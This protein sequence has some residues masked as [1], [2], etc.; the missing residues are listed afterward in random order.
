[1]RRMRCQIE[2]LESRNLLT[3]FSASL[4]FDVTEGQGS[5]RFQDFQPAETGLLFSVHPDQLWF[6]DGSTDGTVQLSSDVDSL[7]IGE[8]VRA[9]DTTY[10]SVGLTSIWRT[11]GTISGSYELQFPDEQ[12]R[13][14]E[15]VHAREGFAILLTHRSDQ[16]EVWRFDEGQANAIRL[17]H[18]PYNQTFFQLP[19]VI[20]AEDNERLYIGR[21]Q[22]SS[23]L[24]ST[25]G[26]VEG[27]EWVSESLEAGPVV[28]SAGIHFVE[29]NNSTRSFALVSGGAVN[30]ETIDI[31]FQGTI[32]HLRGFEDGFLFFDAAVLP[33]ATPWVS[34][35]STETTTPL[36]ASPIVNISP[37]GFGLDWRTEI[38]GVWIF[39]NVFDLFG[40]SF[41][42]DGTLEGTRSLEAKYV[43]ELDDQHLAI[44][45][46]TVVITDGTGFFNLDGSE[47]QVPGPPDFQLPP[48]PIGPFY[49]IKHG[50]LFKEFRDPLFDTLDTIEVMDRT[51]GKF[52]FVQAA[53]FSTDVRQ[54]NNEW[55]SIDPG[56]SQCEPS[57]PPSFKRWNEQLIAPS[58]QGC[59]TLNDTAVF[60]QM[61]FVSPEDKP[62][63]APIF[64]SFKKHE[65]PNSESQLWAVNGQTDLE[66]I[67]SFVAGDVGRTRQRHQGND[68]F[69]VRDTA[70]EGRE[71]WVTDGT[72][73][74]TSIIPIAPG[75][76]SADPTF[77]P[78]NDKV[79]AIASTPETGTE[80]WVV[81]GSFSETPYTGLSSILPNYDWSSTN[82]LDVQLVI[83][84]TPEGLNV[85]W[86]L[87]DDGDFTDA[88]G[89][90]LTLDRAQVGQLDPPMTFGTPRPIHAR[91]RANDGTEYVESS[92]L[93][94]E[95]TAPRLA[96]PLP[97]LPLTIAPGDEL[98][99]EVLVNDFDRLTYTIDYGDG[100]ITVQDH[101]EF[102]HTYEAIGIYEIALTV[103]DGY[104][105]TT[106][107]HQLSVTNEDPTENAF[108]EPG[109]VFGGKEI[110]RDVEVLELA[111]NGLVNQ[112]FTTASQAPNQTWRN[113]NGRFAPDQTA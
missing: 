82:S 96:A 17:G 11:D 110:S 5:S 16:L 103:D 41:R 13:V 28:S 36:T 33:E 71:I 73:E 59:N 97:Q 25:N 44:A 38:D 30:R 106:F 34:R 113:Q 31:T 40:L 67:G 56:Q 111:E 64:L 107:H 62:K 61:D 112:I 89:V 18:L 32:E 45:G 77:V 78:W 68:F 27:S 94:V 83:D 66:R 81:E 58:L 60:D 19:P 75:P 108:F 76:E 22:A 35:G 3:Q 53:F 52:R 42:T 55:Y 63:D 23:Y 20:L 46:E 47:Y 84:G 15:S 104:D 109:Y 102:Q 24:L 4:L 88:V 69:F 87:N 93:G 90:S 74:A 91:V 39:D 100:T 86:D 51:T 57:F 43:G 12:V 72:T 37:Y 1:M 80:L 105:R 10:F 6:T 2:R 9:G 7:S 98:S 50:E 14:I 79:L 95:N 70:D 54:V 8:P 29:K 49:E 26:T 65:S 85:E 99:F 48:P 101:G 92:F 21:P